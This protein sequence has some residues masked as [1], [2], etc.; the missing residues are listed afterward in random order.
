MFI[1]LITPDRVKQE[2]TVTFMKYLARVVFL[3]FLPKTELKSRF[4]YQIH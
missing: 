3:I 4:G 1:C 2:C